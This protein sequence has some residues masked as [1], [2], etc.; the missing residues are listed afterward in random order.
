MQPIK[1]KSKSATNAFKLG[2]L[3]ELLARNSI[4]ELFNTKI[5]LHSIFFALT[6]RRYRLIASKRNR[7]SAISPDGVGE[8]SFNLENS[9][10]NIDL[11]V[12]EKS[13]NIAMNND[14]DHKLTN[15]SNAVF[16]TGHECKHKSF[17]ITKQKIEIKAYLGSNHHAVLDLEF[18]E[19]IT[20][21][22]KRCISI[23]SD[24]LKSRVR[25]RLHNFCSDFIEN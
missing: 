13:H 25:C 20:K 8:S 22:H 15:N 11:Q 19:D 17:L 5:A 7:I 3:A 23:L 18:E 24:A 21:F 10:E 9:T 12:Y 14:C 16:A 1:K 6:I 4:I 2:H